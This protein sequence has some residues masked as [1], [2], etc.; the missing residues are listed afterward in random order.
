MNI[1]IDKKMISTDYTIGKGLL[2]TLVGFI[3]TFSEGF[4]HMIHLYIPTWLE[5]MGTI[6]KIFAQLFTIGAAAT[7]IWGFYFKYEDRINRLRKS[8]KIIQWWNRLNEDNRLWYW[9]LF[10]VC[11]VALLTLI[12]WISV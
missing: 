9:M 11:A 8:N 7:T 2:T 5:P 4:H 10:V 12:I 6:I 1:S 3:V